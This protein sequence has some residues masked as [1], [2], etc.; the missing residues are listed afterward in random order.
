MGEYP[1][2]SNDDITAINIGKIHLESSAQMDMATVT[3]EF[4]NPS[5]ET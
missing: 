5:T 4:F 1:P 2:L 3:V